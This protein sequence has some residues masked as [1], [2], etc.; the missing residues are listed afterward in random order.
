MKRIVATSAATLL[1]AAGIAMASGPAHA[2][3]T[4]ALV[5]CSFGELFEEFDGTG[6]GSLG[7]ATSGTE[8]SVHEGND[9]AWFLT[10]DEGFLEGKEGWME[11]DCVVFIA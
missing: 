6:S 11:R 10:V 8:L 4:P 2:S 3:T 7:F 1:A 5:D 9:D